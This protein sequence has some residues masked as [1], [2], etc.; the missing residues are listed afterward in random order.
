MDAGEH[1]FKRVKKIIQSGEDRSDDRIVAEI[2][3]HFQE[4]LQDLNPG[5]VL[6][7]FQHYYQKWLDRE[8]ENKTLYQL[9][10]SLQDMVAFF[11]GFDATAQWKFSQEEWFFIVEGVNQMAEDMDLHRL[12]DM[13]R[14]LVERGV[15]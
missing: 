13:V 11:Q 7:M 4:S 2:R 12:N 5:L 6:E 8:D 10:E 14:Y 9:G 3:D 1:F 15:Y